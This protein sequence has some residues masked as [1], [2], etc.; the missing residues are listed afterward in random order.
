MYDT[1][2]NLGRTRGHNNRSILGVETY[3]RQQ[4]PFGVETYVRQLGR[5]V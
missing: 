4:E 5:R 2:R 1:P 3:V